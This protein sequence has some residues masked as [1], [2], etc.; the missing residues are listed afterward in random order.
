MK[1]VTILGSNTMNQKREYH[2]KISKK[3]SVYDQKFEHH[4]R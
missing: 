4:T 1:L 3:G 2:I